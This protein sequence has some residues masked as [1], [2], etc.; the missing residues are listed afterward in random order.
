MALHDAYARVTPYELVFP[1]A[2]D[3]EALAARID[4]EAEARGADPS[5]PSQFVTLGAVAA[6]VRGLHADETPPGALHRL[7]A[8]VYHAVRFARAG[9]P[10]YL[11]TTAAARDLV[12]RSPGA[13]PVPPAGSGY[14]QLPQHLFWARPEEGAAPESVDGVFWAAGAAGGLHVMLATGMRPDRP[15]LAVVPLPEAPLAEAGLWL[16]VDVRGDGA[17]FANVLPGGELDAL[18]SLR[19]AGEV[20]KLLARFFALVREHGSE[21]ARQVE[22]ATVEDATVT[23]ATVR[24]A[25]VR[26]ATVRDPA[27]PPP[28]ALRFTRVTPTGPG[29]SRPSKAGKAT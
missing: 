29:R 12:G 6:F 18:Y 23:D 15:G 2:E 21:L 3:A 5:D 10:L 27:A 11:L 4:E 28:A 1:R 13:E 25:T 7:G 8:L 17:D 16:D 9:R 26:D 19:T 22:G 14:V 20:L 24:D